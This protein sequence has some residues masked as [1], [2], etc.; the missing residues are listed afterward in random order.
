MNTFRV[1]LRVSIYQ[2]SGTSAGLTVENHFDIPEVNFMELCKILA[3]F[4]E[5]TIQIKKEKG[6]KDA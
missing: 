6:L 1:S 5:L 2:P 4:E 3:R